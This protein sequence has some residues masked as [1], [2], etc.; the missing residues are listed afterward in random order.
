MGKYQNLA[1]DIVKNVGGRENINGLT[2]CVTRLRF[3]LKDESKANDDVIKEM[4]GV[5][6]LIKSAGQY[7]VVIGNHVPDVFEDVCDVAGIQ[8]NSTA[9]ETK[10]KQSLGALIIDFI[11]GV[12]TPSL[13]VLTACG[14][15]KGLLALASFFGWIDQTQGL[16]TLLEGIGD[17]LFYFFPII[18]GYTTANKL[19]I[20]PFLG[21]CIGAGLVYPTLQNVDLNI[22]GMSINVSYASTVLPVII[23]TIFAS[24]I[25]KFFN[26]ILRLLQ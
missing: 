14:M 16:Y 8:G 20:N 26:K 10:T 15:I 24:Y 19:K 18:L 13:A 25:Y 11:S 1:K 12:M 17:S 5:V 7:Q 6:T 22:L 4:D 23:T 2:H 21:M 3:K 9:S